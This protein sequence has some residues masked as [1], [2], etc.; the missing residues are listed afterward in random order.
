MNIAKL[1]ELLPDTV[2]QD[3]IDFTD[4]KMKTGKN[5]TRVTLDRLL[6]DTEKEQMN[7]KHFVGLDCIAAYRYAPEIKKSY[8]YVV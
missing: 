6:T 4:V 7:N 8:F 2:K 1:I 3:I 5:G